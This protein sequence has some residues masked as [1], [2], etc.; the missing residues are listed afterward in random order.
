M[1]L[2]YLSSVCNFATPSVSKTVVERRR[3]RE[4]LKGRGRGLFEALSRHLVGG[5]EKNNDTYQDSRYPGQNSN[6]IQV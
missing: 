2:S 5:T 1:L 4:N 6:R 3:I